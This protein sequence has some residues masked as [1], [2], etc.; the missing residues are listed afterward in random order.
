MQRLWILL[1]VIVLAACTGPPGPPGPKGDTGP[2][3]LKGFPGIRG[4]QGDRG[5]QGPQGNPGTDGEPGEPGER[6][7]QGP[8]G[9]R[10]EQ[11]E[12][13]ERGERGAQGQPGAQGPQGEPGEQ[14]LPAGPTSCPETTVIRFPA[15]SYRSDW[16]AMTNQDEVGHGLGTDF[17][18]F[19]SPYPPCA[20]RGELLQPGTRMLL[21]RDYHALARNDAPFSDHH[22]GSYEGWLYPNGVDPATGYE[23]FLIEGGTHPD[24]PGQITNCAGIDLFPDRIRLVLAHFTLH[25]LGPREAGE[26][27]SERDEWQIEVSVGPLPEGPYGDPYRC[28]ADPEGSGVTP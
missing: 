21:V 8:P 12:Q 1:A 22:E 20:S 14:G 11:G 23:Q 6:G 2:P 28:N 25:D 16:D 3:G 5:L 24:Y 15:S 7:P 4:E 19:E 9:Q 27:V 10:G 13:G 26:L 18:T 17:V